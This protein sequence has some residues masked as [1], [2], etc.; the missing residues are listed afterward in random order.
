[1]RA[2]AKASCLKP[3]TSDMLS[4]K[5]IE[6]IKKAIAKY[7]KKRSASM[8]ALR[9]AQEESGYLTKEALEQIAD[10]LDMTPVQL[11]E[12]AAFYTMYNKKP[13]GKHH[14]Q[15]CTNVSCSLLGSEHI[16]EFLSKKLG[17]KKGE[18]T[19]DKK[20]TLSE[21]E[22]LGSCGTAPMMQINDDYYENLTEE[23]I[24]EILKGL[25]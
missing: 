6:D 17:V 11:N 22:C 7:P 20:F 8:D 4:N 5:A 12:V 24:E 21:V 3:L 10:M 15:V 19:S 16:V 23:T 18:T 13:V 14:V 9:I 2:E 25:K 1:M